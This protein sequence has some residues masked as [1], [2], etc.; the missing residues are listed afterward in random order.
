MHS[1]LNTSTML[2]QSH[3]PS[4]RGGL[5]ELGGNLQ[6]GRH[7]FMSLNSA[8]WLHRLMLLKLSVE[9]RVK[10]NVCEKES[11]LCPRIGP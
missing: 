8:S 10:Y 2:K 7:L 9:S 6:H 4:S 11:F 5:L 3:V 1:D